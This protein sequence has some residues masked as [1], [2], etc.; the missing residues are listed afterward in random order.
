MDHE[1]LTGACGG[2]D[3]FPLPNVAEF[4]AALQAPEVVPPQP[5]LKLRDQQSCGDW[6]PQPF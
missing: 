2:G 5:V 1:I 6:P 4:T 3:P